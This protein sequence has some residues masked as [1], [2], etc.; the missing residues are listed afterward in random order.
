MLL[1]G[2][3][4]ESRSAGLLDEN[5]HFHKGLFQKSCPAFHAA[6]P[7]TK[8]AVLR[9]DGNFYSSYQDVLYALYDHIPIGGF[10]IFDDVNAGSDHGVM[11]AWKDFK[12]EQGLPEELIPVS[13]DTAFFRKTVL[14][15][16]GKVDMKFFRDHDGI[17]ARCKGATGMHCLGPIGA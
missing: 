13:K 2:L 4:S 3:R 15:A 11:R 16:G 14:P 17:R 8:I 12:A 9:V 1:T 6:N 7:D 10:V 5:V